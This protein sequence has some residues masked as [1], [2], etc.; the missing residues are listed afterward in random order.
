M[1]QQE[2]FDAERRDLLAEIQRDRQA[3]T[4][5]QRKF[6]LARLIVENFVPKRFQRQLMKRARFNANTGKWELPALELAGNNVHPPRPAVTAAPS[7]VGPS[8]PG[9]GA[10]LNLQLDVVG[11]TTR[12]RARATNC[13]VTWAV[14]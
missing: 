5:L 9:R 12:V 14:V 2:D 13:R 11:P 1:L 6:G 3:R 7:A 4:K 10:V 8:V